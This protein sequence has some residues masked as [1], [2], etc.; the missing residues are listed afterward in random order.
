MDDVGFLG[1]DFKVVFAFSSGPLYV[2]GVFRLG[3][4]GCTCIWLF[5]FNEHVAFSKK[6]KCVAA[7]CVSG[8][9][10]TLFL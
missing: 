1:R 8:N 6:K 10:E 4:V 2:S 5:P 9:I 7:V 3:C